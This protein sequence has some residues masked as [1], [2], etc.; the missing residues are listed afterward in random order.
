MTSA[1]GQLSNQW[2]LASRRQQKQ[3]WCPKQA[4]NVRMYSRKSLHIICSALMFETRSWIEAMSHTI[5]VIRDFKKWPL[6][7]GD[8]YGR[9]AAMAGFTVYFFIFVCLTWAL[10]CCSKLSPFMKAYRAYARGRCLWPQYGFFTR[11]SSL[12]VLIT[13]IANYEFGA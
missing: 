2:R 3:L 9:V 1:N 8:R 6:Y 10:W 12:L 11:K 13:D 5:V 7:T 4:T